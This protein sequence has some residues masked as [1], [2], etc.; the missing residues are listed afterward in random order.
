MSF[1]SGPRLGTNWYGKRYLGVYSSY[2]LA[3]MTA[4]VYILSFKY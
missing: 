1:V 2:Q 4:A 3:L